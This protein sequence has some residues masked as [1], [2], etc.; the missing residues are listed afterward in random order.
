MRTLLNI[1]F[2]QNVS[3][4]NLKYLL[5]KP[6]AVAALNLNMQASGLT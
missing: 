4:N 3:N 2:S 6:L 1:S 5:S